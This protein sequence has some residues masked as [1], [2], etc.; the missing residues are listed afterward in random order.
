MSEDTRLRDRVPLLRD[1]STQTS[2]EDFQTLRDMSTQTS[3]ETQT[4]AFT[5]DQYHGR[6]YTLYDPSKGY[7]LSLVGLHLLEDKYM[8]A[9]LE[10]AHTHEDCLVKNFIKHPDDIAELSMF[11]PPKFGIDTLEI[12]SQMTYLNN[13]RIH[14]RDLIRFREKIQR[15]KEAM[16]Q[17]RHSRRASSSHQE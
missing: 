14:L 1:A 15:Q 9:Y 7:N 10:L 3:P 6:F 5:P 13:E 16:L 12:G 8:D 17:A 2:P 11:T 4:E